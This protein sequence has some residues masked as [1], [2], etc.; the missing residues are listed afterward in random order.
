M[1]GLLRAIQ[2]SPALSL[3][4]ASTTTTNRATWDDV[5]VD[6]STHTFPRLVVQISVWRKAEKVAFHGERAYNEEHGGPTDSTLDN[7]QFMCQLW[8]RMGHF[9]YRDGNYA[10]RR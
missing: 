10:G 1:Q 3:L 2:H 4:M 7:Y 9:L 5:M 6:K 8:H